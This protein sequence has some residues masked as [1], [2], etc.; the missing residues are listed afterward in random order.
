ML[1]SSEMDAAV[2]RIGAALHE[3]LDELVEVATAR[4]SRELPNYHTLVPP[5]D[6]LASGYNVIGMV[7]GQLG[8][9]S[10][11]ETDASAK[12]AVERGRQRQSQGVP[13]EDVLRAVRLDFAVLWEPVVEMSRGGDLQPEVGSVA[14]L[15][16]W[17]SLDGVMLALTEG[18]RYQEIAADR[19]SLARRTRAMTNLVYESALEPN[20]L[21]RTAEILGIDTH[22][23]LLIT[24]ARIGERQE[25]HLEMRWRS[26]GTEA[27]VILVGDHVVGITRWS[28]RN[29]QVLTDMVEGFADRVAVVVP[30]VLGMAAA[31]AGIDLARSVLPAAPFGKVTAARDLLIESLVNSQSAIATPLSKV[32]LGGLMELPPNE[33]DRLL[34]TLDGWMEIDGTTTDVARNLYRHRNTVINHLR[35]VEEVTGLSTNRPREVAALVAALHAARAWMPPR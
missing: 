35:R 26:D 16:I 30:P 32:L 24:A 19:E 17:E 34:E 27:H 13:L 7:V 29:S 31:H 20:A 5:D 22:D 8:G 6:L 33:R 21:A 9:A 18:Y 1:T 28:N 15:R 4:I 25:S 23:T 11:T 3:R 14:M 12:A 10:R 2:H